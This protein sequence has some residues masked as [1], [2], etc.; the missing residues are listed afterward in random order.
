M[1]LGYANILG[2]EFDKWIDISY[3][4][5]QRRLDGRVMLLTRWLGMFWPGD[6]MVQV[7]KVL[8]MYVYVSIGN[9]K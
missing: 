7:S 5:I 8:L 2:I 9:D 3:L 1:A 4:C 6:D